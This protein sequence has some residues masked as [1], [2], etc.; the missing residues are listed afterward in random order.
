[1]IAAVPD[2]EQAPDVQDR[3]DVVSRRGLRGIA[4]RDPPRAIEL[5]RVIIRLSEQLAFGHPATKVGALAC[6]DA[7]IAMD[8]RE[9]L[10][11]MR[12]WIGRS[13]AGPPAAVGAALLAKL[14][15][16]LDARR[17]AASWRPR[18]SYRALGL[19]AVAGELP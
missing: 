8:D 13:C 19:Q 2:R 7:A 3:G 10:E 14:T 9:T 4:P 11:M 18:T 17:G 15:A 6:A 1:M 5:G 12:A 16:V